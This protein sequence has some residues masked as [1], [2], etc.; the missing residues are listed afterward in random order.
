MDVFLSESNCEIEVKCREGYEAARDYVRLFQSMLYL[1]AITPFRL[2]F[3]STHSMNAY[4][5]I[6]S[7][8]SETLRQKLPEDKRDGLTSDS[9]TVEVW[10]HEPSLTC[11]QIP[12]L[13]KLSDG[14]LHLAHRYA[15]AW[16]SREK[17]YPHLRAVRFALLTAPMISDL[18]SSLLH[19]WQGIETLFPNVTT[20]VSFR[21]ALMI[22]QLTAGVETAAQT[23]K[24]A[25][26]SYQQRSNAAHGRTRKIG[27]MQWYE[28]WRLLSLCMEA[29]ISRDP[30]PTET[31]LIGELIGRWEE[32]E[33]G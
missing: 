14:S 19:L 20:E 12:T 13:D 27:F 23:Y 31:D 32:H 5:G 10:L 26:A 24:R 25:R 2:P 3:G 28:A 8:D 22:A 30:L 11:I 16:S 6:N 4:S 21:I 17:Q 29:V 1:N 18:S 7:R 9:A 15:E 33:N